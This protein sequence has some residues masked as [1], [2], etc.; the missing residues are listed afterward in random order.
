MK[1]RKWLSIA[2]TLMVLLSLL[3]GCGGSSENSAAMDSMD[4]PMEAPAGQE[5]MVESESLTST[6]SSGSTALPENRK[7]IITVDMYAETE[8][9][10]AL[11]AALDEKITS[12][13]GYVEDQNIYNGSTY[14][15]RRYRS[16]Y[17]TI[18]IPAE[19][20]DKFTDEVEGIANVVRKNKNLE[21]ITLNYVD[22]ESRVAALQAEEA[23]L[24]E[25]MEQAQTMADLLEIEARL[26]NVRY[27]LE[28]FSSRLRTYD[29]QINYATIYL[30]IEE[31]QE[32]TPVAELSTWDRIT[33]GFASSLKNLGDDITDIFVWVLVNSPYLVVLGA[34]AAA[35]ILLVRRGRKRK[36]AKKAAK[37]EPTNSSEPENKSE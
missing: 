35:V 18:R 36:A 6:G 11:M 15:D 2:L 10:D 14:A 20:V 13:S 8:D 3:A 32:Y 23:R 17:L 37:A 24:L 30:D 1:A 12:L 27:E 33:Q 28:S 7:W 21:D 31:V 9:L 25:F 29:N 26:T 19:D 16:A 34:V 5:E 4:T 22:T